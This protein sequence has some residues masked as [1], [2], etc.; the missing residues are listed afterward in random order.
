[1]LAA[2]FL[3]LVCVVAAAP[4]D[5]ARAIRQV[6]DGQVEDWN[7]EDLD[8][9]LE[10]YW[11]SPRLVFLSNDGRSEGWDAVRLRY[12]K[13][14]REGG[15]PMGKL[16]FEDLEIEPLGPGTAFARG[17][18]RLAMPDGKAPTGLFT[19]VLRK[20]PEGWRI[21]HDHTSTGAP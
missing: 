14:Y 1:M 13:R 2:P 10:G 5:E 17:R 6:L 16:A 19:L 12:Q 9:F 18:F 3:A 7:R 8:A 11:N 15:K 21:I 4:G 20:F